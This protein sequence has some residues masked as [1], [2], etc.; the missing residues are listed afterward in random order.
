MLLK[1]H[2]TDYELLKTLN[3]N[4]DSVGILNL[5]MILDQFCSNTSSM[6]SAERYAVI[7]KLVYVRPIASCLEAVRHQLTIGEP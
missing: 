6:R 3:T 2:L 1:T 7:E 4:L 5:S